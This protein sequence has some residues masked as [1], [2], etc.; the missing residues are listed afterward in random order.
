MTAL[1]IKS[2]RE[3]HQ[4]VLQELRWD[5]QVDEM[6]VGVE[7]D[8][9]VVTLTGTVGS[10]AQKMAA[11]EAAHR[12]AGVL[13]VANDIQVKIPYVQARNDTDIA[14]A[15]RRALQWDTLVP[16]ENIQTTVSNGWVTLEGNVPF[17]VDKHQAERAI[18]NLAG[19]RGV[20]N[21]L[22]ITGSPTEE[23]V[24]KNAIEEALE[25]RADRE[26]R[27][28]LVDVRDGKVS[29]TGRVHS[30]NEKQAVLGAAGF[31]PGV[32]AVEDHLKIDPTI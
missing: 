29:L 11:L 20:T 32:H 24:V 15:A 5:S 31:A 8:N 7:V 2:D 27:R 17:W 25:R 28:I 22:T 18:S 26:A 23:K 3:I 21:H 4:A 12:V 9:G 13:D 14:L 16:D 19:V 1:H 6:D 10:Y 30:W